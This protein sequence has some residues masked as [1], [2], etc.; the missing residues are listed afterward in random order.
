MLAAATEGAS[1]DG[2]LYTAVGVIITAICALIGVIVRVRSHRDAT[3]DGDDEEV[4]VTLANTLA[5]EHRARVEAERARDLAAAE[6]DACE[7]READR[8]RRRPR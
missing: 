1:S 3:P 7:A 8:S 2:A 4:I 6:R 5:K